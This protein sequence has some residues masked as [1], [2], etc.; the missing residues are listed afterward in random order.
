MARVRAQQVI[1]QSQ[2]EIMSMFDTLGDLLFIVN[3]AGQIIHLNSTAANRLGQKETD[4]VGK[5][6]LKLYQS[7]KESEASDLMQS[8]KSG[9]V[10]Q[11]DF[12]LATHSGEL[13]KT[14]TRI[15][16][17]QHAGT[18]VLFIVSRESSE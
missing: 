17:G 14:K 8:V 4:L 11:F 1:L 9:E 6:I 5:N 16:R 10:V 7:E 15:V 12:P 18:E 13:I 3:Q 2:A